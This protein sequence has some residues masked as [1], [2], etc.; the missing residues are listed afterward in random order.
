MALS[1]LAGLLVTAGC[2]TRASYE[3]RQAARYG[4]RNAASSSAV[5]DGTPSPTVADASAPAATDTGA[6][7]RPRRTPPVPSRRGRRRG[8]ARPWRGLGSSAVRPAGAEA[9]PAGGGRRPSPSADPASAA[10]RRGRRLHQSAAAAAPAAAGRQRR[11]CPLPGGGVKAPLTIGSITHMSG[12]AAS[13]TLPGLD[14]LQL[15]VKA[16][17]PGAG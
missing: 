2:G 5:G 16:R 8:A 12:P 11:P 13:G 10:S 3:D 9:K 6:G 4:V 15:W 7:G 14:G 17:T 1:L